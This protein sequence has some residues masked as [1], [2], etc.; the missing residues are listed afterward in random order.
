MSGTDRIVIE[1]IGVVGG[2]G[3]GISDLSRALTGSVCSP[4]DLRLVDGI[5]NGHDPRLPG[6]RVPPRRVHPRSH[7]AADRPFFAAR[8]PR[9]PPCARGRGT[10]RGGKTPTGHHHRQRLRGDG[11]H[12][13][14]PQ[15]VHRRRRHL[16][17]A[18]L[19]RQLGAQLRGRPHL[20]P[21]WRH[22]TKPHRQRLSHVGSIRPRHRPDLAC[23]R[24]GPTGPV[25]RGRRTVRSDRLS[26]VPDAGRVAGRPHD[27]V[28]DRDGDVDPCG[29]GRLPAA[30]PGER[31]PGRVLHPGR[32][33][34]G[35][36]A[37]SR[38]S[39]SRTGLAGS[40]GGRLPPNRADDTRRWRKMP[41]SR[42][43]P[44][45]TGPCRPGRPSTWRPPRSSS[46]GG[47]YSLPRAA[48]SCDFPATVP[49][50]GEPVGADRISCLTL[51]GDEAYGLTTLGRMESLRK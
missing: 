50:G 30:R 46:R 2:F 44:P 18:D 8:P 47:A 22:G 6:R 26:P 5:R 10:A 32:I 43:T 38:L 19:F 33:D 12:L 40:G 42:A 39:L 34:H 13:C 17:V 16:R 9:E 29:G 25:R 35:K 20:H 45:C 51:A 37:D 4:G 24:K 21:T 49:V 23:G 48:T 28:T 15:V 27:P 1:G 31:V 11:N 7:I 14:V 36:P 3:C 41:A